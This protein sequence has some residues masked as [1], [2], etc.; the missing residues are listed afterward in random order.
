VPNTYIA[1]NENKSKFLYIQWRVSDI[2]T[3]AIISG[4]KNRVRLLMTHRSYILA[5]RGRL[6][7]RKTRGIMKRIGWPLKSQWSG[8]AWWITA[9]RTRVPVKKYRTKKLNMESGDGVK[10]RKYDRRGLGVS[11]KINIIIYKNTKKQKKK[12]LSVTMCGQWDDGVHASPIRHFLTRALPRPSIS[13]VLCTNYN[14]NNRRT[15]PLY[16]CDGYVYYPHSVLVTGIG[17]L[18]DRRVNHL[19]TSSIC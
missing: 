18:R 1:W 11:A 13:R 7:A 6:L 8:F 9:W 5:D 16:M 2:T 17:I 14:N 15:Y 19:E 3:P 4:L 12:S 10:Q